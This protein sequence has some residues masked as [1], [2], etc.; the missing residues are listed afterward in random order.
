MLDDRYSPL[1][2]REKLPAA[3]GGFFIFQSS[4]WTATAGYRMA[5]GG[6]IEG[7]APTQ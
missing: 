6:W 5:A 1:R 4:Q 2:E 7:F 3:T